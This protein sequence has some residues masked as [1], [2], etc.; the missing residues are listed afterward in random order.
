M[1][2]ALPTG[3]HSVPILE[4]LHES[5]RSVHIV[6][7][8]EMAQEVT[9]VCIAILSATSGSKV[10]DQVPLSVTAM[11]KG[12]ALRTLVDSRAARSFNR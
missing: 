3:T 12:M 6:N 2:T 1:M 4:S 11:I 10:H 8:F 5:Y 9:L 7:P